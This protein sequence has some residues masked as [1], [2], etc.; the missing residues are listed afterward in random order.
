MTSTRGR[1]APRLAAT[2]RGAAEAERELGGQQLAGDAA[3]AVGAEELARAIAPAR[4][5]ETPR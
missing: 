3:D 2:S 4:R 1:S 5:L